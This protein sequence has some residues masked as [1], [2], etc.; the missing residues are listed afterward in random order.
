MLSAYFEIPT[1]FSGY[2]DFFFFLC[3]FTLKEQYGP[4]ALS[5]L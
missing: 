5:Y 4:L 1:E 2:L 3:S